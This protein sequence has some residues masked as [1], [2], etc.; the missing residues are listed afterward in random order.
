M[1]EACKALDKKEKKSTK[2][3]AKYK[4]A[5]KSNKALR[6]IIKRVLRRIKRKVKKTKSLGEVTKTIE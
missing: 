1:R 2:A 3:Q 5:P 6:R 4:F